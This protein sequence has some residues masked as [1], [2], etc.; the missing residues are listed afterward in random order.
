MVA[1]D[2]HKAGITG[3]MTHVC[4]SRH[5]QY[6]FQDEFATYPTHVHC[7]RIHERREI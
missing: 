5:Q 4:G 6:S 3:L 1:D 7:V 2:Y